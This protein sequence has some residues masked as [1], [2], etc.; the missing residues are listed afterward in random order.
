VDNHVRTTCRI[1]QRLLIENVATLGRSSPSLHE[2]VPFLVAGKTDDLVAAVGKSFDEPVT[3]NARGSGD[4]DLH[5]N[6]LYETP[7]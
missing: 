5:F 6:H 1:D 3:E 7:R 2:V 4:E